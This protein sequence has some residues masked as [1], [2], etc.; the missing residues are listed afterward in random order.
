MKGKSVKA[1]S[2]LIIGAGVGGI[3]AAIH[4]A[5]NGL[6][7]TVIEKNS[8][9]GGRCGHFTRAGHHF[10]TGPTLVLP[11]TVKYGLPPVVKYALPTPSKRK[12]K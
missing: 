10:D 3:T 1:Q 7:V 4:L 2:V 8:H 11:P 12:K 5:R 6:R 9:P